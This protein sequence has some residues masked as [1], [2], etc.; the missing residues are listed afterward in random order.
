MEQKLRELKLRLTEINDL[1][2]AAAV[3]NWDQSTYM[4]AGGAQPAPASYPPLREFHKK[5]SSIRQ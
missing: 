1:E 5:N 3:L 4:P 2:M